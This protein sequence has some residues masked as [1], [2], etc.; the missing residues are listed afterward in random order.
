MKPEVVDSV[1][2]EGDIPQFERHSELSV[3][4]LVASGGLFADELLRPGE[5]ITRTIVFFVPM[6][7]YDVLD[8]VTEIPSVAVPGIELQWDVQDDWSIKAKLYA[9]KRNQ[10]RT[11]VPTNKLGDY[12]DSGLEFQTAESHS[13]VSLWK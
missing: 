6:G 2:S 1:N 4:K 8:V 12:T 3:S 5:T 11:E 7:T 10:T 13:R 9:M